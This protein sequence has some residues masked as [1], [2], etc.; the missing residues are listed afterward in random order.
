MDTSL[1][2]TSSQAKIPPAGFTVTYTQ[3]FPRLLVLPTLQFNERKGI[4]SS[5]K[6]LN[7]MEPFSA[8]DR[9][10]CAMLL[11]GEALRYQQALKKCDRFALHF[12]MAASKR[13]IHQDI[14]ILMQESDSRTPKHYKA[15]CPT[16]KEKDNY[17]FIKTELASLRMWDVL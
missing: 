15:Q 8:N 13:A 1:T 2:M 4:R 3:G 9:K 16:K 5:L 11:A 14:E 10:A 7:T 6:W 12:D 17:F